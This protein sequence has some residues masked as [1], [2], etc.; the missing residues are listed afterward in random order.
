VL[1]SQIIVKADGPIQA[2]IANDTALD[3]ARRP[4][5]MVQISVLGRHAGGV[6]LDVVAPAGPISVKVQDQRLGLPAIPGA[7]IA[8]RP[9]WMVPAPLSDVADS[10][11]VS[12]EFSI[13]D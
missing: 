6:T 5:E 7:T 11:I 2:L 12:D 10:T 9:G 1:D 13:G 8:P 4:T 3:M